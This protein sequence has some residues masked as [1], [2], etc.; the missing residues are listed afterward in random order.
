ML[1]WLMVL[2]VLFEIWYGVAYLVAYVHIRENA[3]LL[4]VGQATLMMLVFIY[5]LA[6]LP[7][8]QTSQLLVLGLLLATMILQVA[9][10]RLVAS[11]ARYAQ[12]YPRGLIDVLTFRRRQVDLKRRVRTK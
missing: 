1:T 9:W 5:L 11:Q 3:L 8:Q 7:T 10:R 2:V 4:Q 12:N 6:T